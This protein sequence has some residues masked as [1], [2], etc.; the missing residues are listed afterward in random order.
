MTMFTEKE[1]ATVAS[2]MGFELWRGAEGGYVLKRQLDRL[3]EEVIEVSSLVLV[4]DFL[5]H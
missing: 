1:V 4:A 5:K 2:Y 3:R